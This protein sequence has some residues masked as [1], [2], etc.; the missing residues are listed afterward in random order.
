M[1]VDCTGLGVPGV[2]VG[3]LVGFALASTSTSF[4]LAEVSMMI[5]M[6]RA[7]FDTVS[8]WITVVSWAAA[9]A[10][11]SRAVP[12]WSMVEAGVRRT[13]WALPNGPAPQTLEVGAGI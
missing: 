12:R 8:C 3:G 4:L 2:T 7:K 5:N 10:R 13:A 6:V 9:R 11:L 1:L